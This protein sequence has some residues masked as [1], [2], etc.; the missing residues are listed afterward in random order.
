MVKWSMILLLTHGPRQFRIIPRTVS[1]NHS[2][3]PPKGVIPGQDAKT[4]RKERDWTN[5]VGGF[6]FNPWKSSQIQLDDL[7]HPSKLGR[8]MS[9]P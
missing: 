3:A 2:P 9:Q 8:N 5:L 1:E 4:P 6:S 7:K